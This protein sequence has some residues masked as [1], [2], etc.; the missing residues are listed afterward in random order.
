MSDSLSVSTSTSNN[1][2]ELIKK[3]DYLSSEVSNVKKLVNMDNNG[4][5][6][7]NQSEKRLLNGAKRLK[8][9]PQRQI[10]SDVI[11]GSSEVQN[12]A[13]IKVIEATEWF[14]VSRFDPQQDDEDMKKWLTEILD[15]PEVQ[16]AKLIPKNR[17]KDQLSF[18]SYKIGVLKS[19]RSTVLNPSVWPRNVTVKP[20]VSRPFLSNN[21]HVP[22]IHVD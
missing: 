18:V 15:T 17:S 3:I 4:T 13:P 1:Y 8:L 9:T 12:S 22:H 20:F 7:K 6:I 11:H 14:H 10:V 5:P 19:K 21:Y 2:D 16:V